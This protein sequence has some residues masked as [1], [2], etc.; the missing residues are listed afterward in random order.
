[1][2][3][4]L[5]NYELKAVQFL[6]D[7]KTTLRV[8][9]IVTDKHFVDDTAERDVYKITLTNPRGEHSFRF[10]DSLRNTQRR[11]FSI[12]MGL[13]GRDYETARKLGFKPNKKGVVNQV[14]LAAA[15]TRIPGAYDVLA[16]LYMP[17]AY[18]FDEFCQDT[19]YINSPLSEY[20]QVLKIY[21][22]GQ[23]L[24]RALT[25]MFTEEQLLQLLE[26]N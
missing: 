19:G 22:D 2:N 21:T 7:T 20:K 13:T 1:M 12:N 18:T 14:E 17:V 23:M 16:N 3:T 25:Q 26:I 10:G 5:N 8:E 24:N 11:L 15:R 4:E 6:A 9:Y